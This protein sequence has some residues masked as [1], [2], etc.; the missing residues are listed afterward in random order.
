MEA[1]L[2][3]METPRPRLVHDLLLVGAYGAA[4]YSLY[5]TAQVFWYLPAGLRF[6]TLL[7]LPYRRW[8]LPLA[9]ELMIYA[10]L[11]AP[12]VAEQGALVAV[13]LVANPV[14]AACGPYWLRRSGGW[15]STQDSF[16]GMARLLTALLLAAAGAT[17]VNLFFPFEE[18]TQ[19][20]PLRL[21]LQLLL[22]D[23]IGLLTVVPLVLMALH[24]RPDAAIWRCW[25]FD[26][27]CVLL[28]TLLLYLLLT[29][30]AGEAQVFFFSA[31]LSLVPSIYFAVRSGWRGASLALSAATV[32]VASSGAFS[33]ETVLTVEAQAFLAVAG[34]TN[35]L[36]GA[37]YDSLRSHQ[38][39]LQERNA[40]LIAAAIRQERLAREL[41]EAA[42]RN[43][44]LSEQVRRWITSEL[45]DEI[46]QNLVAIQTRLRLLQRQ[47]GLDGSAL[48]AEVGSTLDSLRQTV[49]GLMSSLRPAGLEEFG[50]AQALREGA[51]RSLLELG[52]IG[53][54]VQIDDEADGLDALDDSARTALYRIVQEAATNTVRHAAASQFRVR[55]RVQREADGWCVL[56]ALSDDGRGF[57]A[58]Q[59]AAG[60]GLQGVRDRVLSLGG[61][62]RLRSSPAGTRL[63]LRLRFPDAEAGG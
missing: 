62:L 42:G 3:R 40:G 23:T 2:P 55:L 50:L 7:W 34:G 51:I 12:L 30:Q 44:E 26:I 11:Y 25:R 58:G 61:R 24:A 17:L 21:A 14:F 43:L 49:S 39:Q 10:A 33:G 63:Q 19:L 4:F 27:P 31:L 60:I 48:W 38:R 59:R 56:L 54:E 47:S 37:L 1:I 36:L 9:A 22:G 5:Q 20:S 6:V 52:G 15:S 18:S 41:R 16:T 45:H 28:P 8:P 35:L 29:T 53:F 32:T 46:G 13:A 57:D